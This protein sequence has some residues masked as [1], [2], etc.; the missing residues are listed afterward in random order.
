MKKIA[1]IFMLLIVFSKTILAQGHELLCH[2]PG[3]KGLWCYI[4]ISLKDL[5]PG[6]HTYFIP[7]PPNY[8][9]GAG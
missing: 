1:I 3:C 6:E 5:K 2:D 8:S 9:S 4:S 7:A